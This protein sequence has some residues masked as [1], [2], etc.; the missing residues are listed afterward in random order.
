MSQLFAAH[1]QWATRPKE[2]RFYTLKEMHELAAQRR[3]VSH[4]SRVTMNN[5]RFRGEEKS[6]YI[7]GKETDAQPTH[8]AFGQLC[9]LLDAPPAYM[10]KLPGHLVATNL[11]WAVANNPG[12]D[13]MK[14]M[15]ANSTE[16]VVR[17]F[18][19]MA[20]GRLWDNDVLAW[21]RQLTNDEQD[22]HRPPA[23]TDHL[24]PSGLYMSDR[25]FFVFLVNES[26]RIDDGSDKGLARGFF[27]WNTEVGQLSFGFQAFLYQYVCGNHIVWNAKNLFDARIF[28]SGNNVAFRVEKQVR[29]LLNQY[30]Q[31]SA[32]TEQAIITTAR[33]KTIAQSR[34]GAID[35]LAQRKFGYSP[36]EAATIVTHAEGLGKD[37]TVLWHLVDAATRLSQEKGFSDARTEKDRQA[38]KLLMSVM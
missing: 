15:W 8:W 6:I 10:R 23:V 2:E 5:I 37:P 36:T 4:E 20:Y 34:D 14:M 31:S 16:M 17:A 19:T 18:N 3:I 32:A 13:M 27:C 25:N 21:L 29:P 12:R 7:I 22:W 24:Y 33:Q 26:N 30:I 38:G 35:W 28:H 11:N 1:K 9:D